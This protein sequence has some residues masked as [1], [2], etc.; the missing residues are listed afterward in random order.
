VTGQTASKSALATNSGVF[1]NPDQPLMYSIVI[2]EE[3]IRKQEEKVSVAR[4][5]LQEALMK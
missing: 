4:R 3:D 5:K 2:E 1:L